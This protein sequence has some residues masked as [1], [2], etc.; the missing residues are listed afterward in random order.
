M[1]LARWASGPPT[2][3]L[4]R[5]AVTLFDWSQAAA[6][7]AAVRR[8]NEVNIIIRRGDATLA[9]QPVRIARVSGQSRTAQGTM[10]QESRGRVV[11]MG[12]P[13]LDIQPDDRFSDASGTLFR[14]I[15]VRPNRRAAIVAEAEVVE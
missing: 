4:G 7:L 2:L 5:D 15:L 13:S 12:S 10:T 3:Q 9:A 6:D 8:E 11:V 14:V 1:L